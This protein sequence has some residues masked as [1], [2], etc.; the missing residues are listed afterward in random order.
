MASTRMPG[1]DC[2][3]Y[4]LPRAE[5]RRN[6]LTV[7]TEDRSKLRRSRIHALGCIWIESHLEARGRVV[8]FEGDIQYEVATRGRM[9]RDHVGNLPLHVPTRVGRGPDR[10]V[11]FTHLPLPRSVVARMAGTR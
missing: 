9:V 2:H 4:T 7:L 5:G 6:E 10:N 1:P 8:R 11:G 3:G